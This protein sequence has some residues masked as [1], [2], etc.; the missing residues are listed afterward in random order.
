[1][2]HSVKTLWLPGNLDVFYGNRA[3]ADSTEYGVYETII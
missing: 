3:F 1:M 2:S